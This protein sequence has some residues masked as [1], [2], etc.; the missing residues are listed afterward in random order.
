MSMAKA[1]GN[2]D[3]TITDLMQ[4][5]DAVIDS[6]FDGE[7]LPYYD[8]PAGVVHSSAVDGE[9]EIEQARR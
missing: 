7:G 2:L 4:L 9:D 1:M 3:A 5:T 8:E 6:Q